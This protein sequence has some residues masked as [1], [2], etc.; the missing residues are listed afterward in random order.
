MEDY[1]KKGGACMSK[2]M[3]VLEVIKSLVL[4]Y[5]FTGIALAALAFAVYKWDLSETV[6][7]V[8][9][10]AVYVIS[11]FLGGFIT[12]KRVRERKFVWGMLLGGL[13]IIIIY[14]VSIIMSASLDVVS[15]ASITAAL[16]CLGGGMLGGMVS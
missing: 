13:Y 8:S 10:L 12:G 16:L 3:K 5:V 1:H 15:T 11:S 14:G 2:S 6:V 7:T 4:A 9:I